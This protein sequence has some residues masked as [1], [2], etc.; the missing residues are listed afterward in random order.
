MIDGQPLAPL[1]PPAV[2]RLDQIRVPTLLIVG[3][4]DDPEV[5]RAAGTMEKEIPGARKVVI[6]DAAHVPSMERPAEFD[7]AV[8]GFLRERLGM[9]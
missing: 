7:Q 6:S 3:A 8:L 4:L 2:Q 5:L 1:D 9:S